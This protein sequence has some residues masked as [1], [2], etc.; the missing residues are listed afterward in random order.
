MTKIINTVLIGIL[1]VK[2]NFSFAAEN[3]Y[4]IDPP[5]K[6]KDIHKFIAEFINWMINLGIVAATL[7]FIYTGFQ[8]V[9][10][11]GNPDALVKAKNSFMWTVVG[12]LLLI[13]AKV[14][15][16]VIQN[17]LTGLN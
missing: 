9:A 8:F 13:G 16:K 1:L 7:F 17:T 6:I 15:V 11:K 3:K 4:T 14:L 10:A 2:H 12:T 5:L